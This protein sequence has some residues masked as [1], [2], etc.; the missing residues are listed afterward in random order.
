MEPGLKRTVMSPDSDLGPPWA[1]GNRSDLRTVSPLLGH[2]V[3]SMTMK[4]YA[5]VIPGLKA[6]ATNGLADSLL[7]P[8]KRWKSRT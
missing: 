2:S 4:M 3:P 6:R 1:I 7:E 5:H 8:Q